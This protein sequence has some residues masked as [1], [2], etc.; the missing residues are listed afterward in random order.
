[1]HE[2]RKDELTAQKIDTGLIFQRMLGTGDARDYLVAENV[3]EALIAR[4]LADRPRCR[5]GVP[6]ELPLPVAAVAEIHVPLSDMS[7][8]PLA[9]PDSQFYSS[10][11]RR[12]NVVGAAIVQAAITVRE[13]YGNDR[14]ERMLRREGLPDDVIARVLADDRGLRRAR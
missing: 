12:R 6:A 2:L 4:V 14:A 3:P 5:G 11:G 13:R 8:I 10:A 1:M 7:A 9:V